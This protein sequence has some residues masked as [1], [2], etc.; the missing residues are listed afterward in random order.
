MKKIILNYIRLTN[1]KGLRSFEAR[2]HPEQSTIYGSNASGKTTIF[3][4]FLWLLFAKD[5]S[6]RT[7]FQIKHINSNGVN[8]TPK[9]ATV[10][11]L[12]EADGT[13]IA[14]KRV[15]REKWT[16]KRGAEKVE[17]TGH[18]TIY[19]VDD[20]PCT[21]KQYNEKVAMLCPEHL[22]RLIT[23]PLYFSSLKWQAQREILFGMVGGSVP[24]TAIA[25]GNKD[26]EGLLDMLSGKSLDELRRQLAAKKRKLREQL[27]LIPAR[28]D[29]VSRSMPAAENWSDIESDLKKT[30]L[31]ITRLDEQINDRT[32]ASEAQYKGKENILQQLYQAKNKLREITENARN[33]HDAK[34]QQREAL[35]GKLQAKLE[36][37]SQELTRHSQRKERLS[38]TLKT[39]RQDIEQLRAK[40]HVE[41][42]KQLVFGDDAFSCP[43]CGRLLEATDAEAKKAEMQSS[44]NQ[45]K[46]EILRRITQQ[47]QQL[48]TGHEKADK[49][50]AETTA[51]IDE[52]KEKVNDYQQ[53]FEE[54]SSQKIE[55]VAFE[56]IPGHT[57]TVGQIET[58]QKE[59][60][61]PMVGRDVDE[62][63]KEKAI[64]SERLR[65][66]SNTLSLRDQITRSKKRIS[67]LEDQ[68]QILAQE[69]AD[70]ERTEFT[71]E[72]FEKAKTDALEKRVNS[73]FELARF[74]LFDTQINGQ[75]IPTCQA[76]FNNVPFP[77]LNTAMKINCGIDI[78][79][80]ISNHNGISAPVFIDHAE[81]VINLHHT[82]S[83]LIRL[84]VSEKHHS[85]T[86]QNPISD[87][88][89]KYTTE[90]TTAY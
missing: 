52:L 40:W 10:E 43:T 61:K 70:L 79:N 32:K 24:D 23:N 9:E 56:K 68:Q 45:A 76:T 49:D 72:S 22:F 71:I 54:V 26:F 73:M 48:A 25:S 38:E 31:S 46:A 64:L 20:V 1:F 16:R 78:I 12:M 19:H 36:T 81:S 30:D 80:S 84:V 62:L 88:T 7:D 65:S 2:F 33:E 69:L 3:D 89:E 75:E 90:V 18:E 63:R 27:D 41:N 8:G 39:V 60:D 42:E 87:G 59:Y 86:I 17:F 29:E 5:S 74:K 85:L 13:Q 34:V 4:A 21:Q 14:L 77:D 67:E 15:F 55:Q 6:D 47:G 57:E 37:I 82:A 11:A 51:H 44:F 83:Q 66:L 50:L 53:R 58:L 35:R 28:V